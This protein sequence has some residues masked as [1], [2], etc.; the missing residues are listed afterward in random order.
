MKAH[1][2]SGKRREIKGQSLETMWT[3]RRLPTEVV[4]GGSAVQNQRKQCEREMSGKPRKRPGKE[5][6]TM[7]QM[8]V[9]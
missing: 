8:G 2:K 3:E 1:S 9:R 7:V 6:D 4:V 5:R